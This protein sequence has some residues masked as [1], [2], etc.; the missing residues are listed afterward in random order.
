MS[1]AGRTLLRA[2]QLLAGAPSAWR[3]NR[4]RL[5]EGPFHQR[6]EVGSRT[7]FFVPV[8]SGGQGTLLIGPE[9][10][11][12]WRPA[13]R[14]GTG[15]ILLQPRAR[16]A[17]VVIGT[18]N[19][20]SNNVSVVAMGSIVLGD[21]CLLGDQVSIYDC[22]F[23]EVDPRY[24]NRSAGPVLPVVIG[25]NVWLGSRVVVLKGVTIGENSVV[26]AMSVVT[27]SIPANCVAAGNPAR[28]VRSI[29]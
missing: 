25:N 6:M 21:H 28:A 16:C 27:Q 8:R 1:L 20:L 13:P 2:R 5:V 19:S 18:G 9:N 11:L 17:Q 29:D 4:F 7:R 22:D 23:H 15:E 26:A 24:R 10:T 3:V 12:G 14:M